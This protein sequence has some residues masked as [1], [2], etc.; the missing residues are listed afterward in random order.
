MKTNYVLIQIF[1]SSALWHVREKLISMYASLVTLKRMFQLFMR[2][3]VELHNCE[4]SA[5]W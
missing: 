5:M 4:F 1:W 2:I 3:V